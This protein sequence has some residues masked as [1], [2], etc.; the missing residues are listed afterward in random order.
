VL[1]VAGVEPAKLVAVTTQVI[2]ANES[3]ATKV[4]VDELVPMLVAPRF[5]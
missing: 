4:Y 2:A 1:L 3:A 5:H